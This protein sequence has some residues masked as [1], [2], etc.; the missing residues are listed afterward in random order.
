MQKAL[1]AM[2]ILC[3]AA[4]ADL[5]YFDFTVDLQLPAESL[6]IKSVY[7]GNTPLLRFTV[8]N[9]DA[10]YSDATNYNWTFFYGSS[11]TATTGVSLAAS[12]VAGNV[13][14]FYN[15]TN[16][17]FRK[18]G[19]YVSLVMTGSNGVRRTVATGSMDQQ[20][21]AAANLPGTSPYVYPFNW[22]IYSGY[23]GNW[24]IE[25]AN[26]ALVMT[27][28][29]NGTLRLSVS[30]GAATN[31]INN[32]TMTEGTNNYAILTNSTILIGVKTNYA[33]GA[34]ISNVD[35]FVSTSA[36]L[37]GAG[38]NAYTK[39][40]LTNT[41]ALAA[42]ALQI[43]SQT[44]AV[45]SVNGIA[46]DSTGNVNVATGGGSGADTNSVG[47]IAT[48][49]VNVSTNVSARARQSD[50]NSL[51]IAVT[52]NAGLGAT[53]AANFANYLPLSGSSTMNGIVD[54][55]TNALILETSFGVFLGAANPNPYLLW[56]GYNSYATNWH[57]S[58][59]ELDNGIVGNG[60]GLTN[61]AMPT[62]AVAKTGDTMSGALTVQNLITASDGTTSNYVLIGASGDTAAVAQF[63]HHGAARGLYFLKET[64]GVLGASSSLFGG[65]ALPGFS[66]QGANIGG[67]GSLTITNAMSANSYGG[68]GW[69]AA[70]LGLMSND[71]VQVS[72][73]TWIM[74]AGSTVTLTRANTGAP[75]RPVLV[76]T[77]NFTLVLDPSLLTT[78]GFDFVGSWVNTNG[79]AITWPNQVANPNT[80][81]NSQTTGTITVN[82]SM[83]PSAGTNLQPCYIR[84]KN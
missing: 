60:G 53:N 39:A 40:Q 12:S 6:S 83:A 27:T 48:N 56:G 29:A 43:V 59:L 52:N 9:D 69:T 61:I 67:V 73:P 31:G 35:G 46:Y 72:G 23:V 34:A 18:G 77:N 70:S 17:F 57:I 78:N 58:R 3:G 65:I 47:L 55:T 63:V 36:G 11:A 16:L 1:I 81:F 14:S 50:L 80:G 82:F 30:T 64:N 8:N 19:Y 24:P 28:N 13:V 33:N 71:S 22:N 2:L 49:T 62:N 54:W 74:G 84:T 25:S 41:M 68:A 5:P 32:V 10:A 20:W 44:G 66:F 4:R 76:I 51:G 79:F 38:T 21:D 75:N 42:S 26:G 7:S 45:R 37:I 15:S